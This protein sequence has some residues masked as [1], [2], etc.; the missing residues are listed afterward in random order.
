[1]VLLSKWERGE[2][3]IKQIVELPYN[4]SNPESIEK[5]AKSVVKKTFKNILE[6]SV[7]T[8]DLD[9]LITYYNNP[10]SKGGLGNLVEKFLFFYE[11]NSDPNPDFPK[12]GVELKVTPYKELKKKGVYS[13]GERLVI[14]MIPYSQPLDIDINTSHIIEKINLIL[15]MLY[16]REVGKNRTDFV[17]THSQLFSITNKLLEEDFKIIQ[18]D[19]RKIVTKIQNGEAHLLSESDTNYL[20]AST[21][22]ST[23]KKS[24]KPQFYNPDIKAKSRAFS[25]KQGFMTY[26][27]NNYIFKEKITYEAII[28]KPEELYDTTLEDLVLTKINRYKGYSK[29]KLKE[30]FKIIKE[31]KQIYSI[32]AFRMLGI[33]SNNAEEFV[34]ANIV[35]KAIRIE[36]NGKI[37]E[38]M[39]F[40]T[41]VIKEL[42]DEEWETSTFN[43]YFDQTKFLFM[44]Y[45]QQKD[46]YVFEG[47]K[48]WS[49]PIVT[50]EKEAKEDWEKVQ[51]SYNHVEF[52]P[53]ATKVNNTL[54]KPK[55]MNLFF[56]KLHVSKTA[57]IISGVRYGKG[58]TKPERYS[59]IL[60]NGDRMPIQ[61]FWLNK[62]FIAKQIAE[63][64]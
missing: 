34:K 53:T 57:H 56:S 43:D 39:S 60:P 33:T 30:H 44:I 64:F 12:A 10:K 40:P 8:S 2:N 63:F 20:A 48:F 36:E 37:K 22:G 4:D 58:S 17:I 23:A 18:E 3:V 42:L 28:T 25:F 41:F 62:N 38:H 55:D 14:G 29:N 51:N 1:M 16:K 7:E 24:Y 15:L 9:N 50:L 35:V 21:K 46:D 59:D 45:R 27:I 11:P 6:D 26:I 31:S 5:H 19:Y 49:L 52:F 61:S 54:P 47:A 13:A 32:L